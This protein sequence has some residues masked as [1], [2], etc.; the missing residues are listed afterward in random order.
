MGDEHPIMTAFW[1][2][3]SRF[4]HLDFGRIARKRRTVKWLDVGVLNGRPPPSWTRGCGCRSP[5][6]NSLTVSGRP[7]DI[8]M[9]IESSALLPSYQLSE[10]ASLLPSWSLSSIHPLPLHLCYL[11]RWPTQYHCHQKQEPPPY[12]HQSSRY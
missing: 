7:R 1:G 5:L 12:P 9:F 6:F 3:R 10:L 8:T 11:F 2:L 4:S